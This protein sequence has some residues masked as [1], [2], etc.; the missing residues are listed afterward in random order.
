MIVKSK[1]CK[2]KSCSDWH[3]IWK[4]WQKLLHSTKNWTAFSKHAATKSQKQKQKT[5]Q[6]KKTGKLIRKSPKTKDAY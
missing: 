5:K 2:T 6:K 1:H 4:T 3:N